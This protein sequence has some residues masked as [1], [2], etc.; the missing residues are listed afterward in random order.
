MRLPIALMVT[1][2]LAGVLF[3]GTPAAGTMYVTD[4]LRLTV[5]SSP[6]AGGEIVGVI[7]SGQSLEVV[8]EVEKW[9]QVRLPDGREGPPATAIRSAEK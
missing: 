7:Q 4:V 8:S 9:A 5:R 2:A 3:A 1:L 6:G